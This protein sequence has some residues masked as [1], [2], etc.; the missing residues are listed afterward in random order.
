MGH[1]LLL[2]DMRT[3]LARASAADMPQTSIHDVVTACRAE[4]ASIILA[5]GIIFQERS[6]P[7]MAGRETSI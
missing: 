2:R 6:S 4:Q 7:W 1:A 3:G 5:P